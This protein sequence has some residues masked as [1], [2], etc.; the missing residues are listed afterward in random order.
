MVISKVPFA[1]LPKQRNKESDG[2][3]GRGSE[4][5]G[6]TNKYMRVSKSHQISQVLALGHGP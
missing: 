6:V 3:E 5:H 2:K 1:T 4:V